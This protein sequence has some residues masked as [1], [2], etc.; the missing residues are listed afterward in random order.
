MKQLKVLKAFGEEN[1][2]FYDDSEEMFSFIISQNYRDPVFL[3][4]SSGD[5]DGFDINKLVE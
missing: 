5:F 3:V 1:M 4:I 2:R